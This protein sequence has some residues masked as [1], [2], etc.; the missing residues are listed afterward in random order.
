MIILLNSASCLLSPTLQSQNLE[1]IG[2]RDVFSLSGGLNLN[3]VFYTA[4]GLE[5]RRDPYNY[6]ISANLN[7]G[8][9]GWQVPLSFSYSNQNATFQQP[10]NQ[11]GMSPTYKWITA[12]IGYRSMNFSRYT[13]AGHL[14]LG[15]GFEITPTDR[16][17]VSAMYGRLQ[18]AVE[19]DS[20]SSLNMP[21]YKR[22]GGG[23]KITYGSN[24]HA[25]DLIFFKARDDENSLSTPITDEN[26]N[27]EEN[28]VLGLGFNT[29]IM[30][31]LTIKGE[32]ASS[33]ISTDLRAEETS[34]GSIYNS[35]DFLFRPRVSSSFY[36]ALNGTLQYQFS[37]YGFGVS[38][39]RVDPGYR[40]LGA[41]Y[42]NNDLENISLI[43]TSSWL[44]QKLNLNVRL[45]LQK[46]NL[47][48]S[49]LSTMN[50]L[51]T[52]ASVS[53]QVTQRIVTSFNYSNFSTVVNFRPA[54]ELLDRVTPY[55]DLDT[56]NYKQVAQ[57]ASSNI[58]FILNE[59]KERC[60][61]LSMNFSYQE[62]TDLRGG[63][64]QDSGS[65][66]YNIN[67]SYVINLVPQGLTVSLSGNAN[68]S[69]SPTIHNFIFGPSASV[70]KS[71]LDNKMSTHLTSS[72]NNA[73]VNGSLASRIFN[74]RLGGSYTLKDAHQF[75]I[76]M[77]GISRFSPKNETSPMFR[78]FVAEVGYSYH[79]SV[80]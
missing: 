2:Q 19:Q 77:T 38:Y 55:D 30:K 29:T 34:S 11:Y 59:S 57:N 71:F 65:K 48:D 9:Y 25:V 37:K 49:E 26:I 40:T 70:R 79:F 53:Y 69:R 72:Y 61:N 28:L 80:R 46:N 74:L 42:F 45:G 41:Y 43:H 1:S 27:P 12:H 63:E 23:A 18:K 75:S 64:E 22:M 50:R 66:Y 58:N 8:I 13:L 20:T 7:I 35:L 4:N 6:F 47:D 32:F 78:E 67:S 16:L 24:K 3:Q 21:A 17:K 51:S 68:I 33:A 56:L 31:G 44:E 76:N 52:A 54:I 5:N 73:K 14:F 36:K 60:Q 15:G 62:T 10:F 39:E